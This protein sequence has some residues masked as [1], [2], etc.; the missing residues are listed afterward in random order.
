M[1][2]QFSSRW[3]GRVALLGI[4]STAPALVHAQAG[5]GD[6]YLF[7]APSASLS[8]RIGASQPSE[9]SRIF[10]FTSDQLTINKGDLLGASFAADLDIPVSRRLAVTVGTAVSARRS[11]SEYRDFVDNNDL[12]IEQ[13]TAFQR[14]TFTVGMKAYLIAP[15]RS[16]GRFAWVPNRVAPYLSAGGGVSHYKFNQDGDFVDFQ[17]NDV[18]NTTLSSSGWAPSAYG[19]AGIDLS[20]SARAGLTLEGRYDHAKAAMSRDFEGF[21]RIDLSGFAITTGLHFRF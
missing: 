10:A 17:T 15:G 19:A 18:F 12:P 14:A 21:D 2:P 1:I 8:I 3:I 5:S 16:V 9:N 20:L 11:S 7:R 4:A 13:S 6:G